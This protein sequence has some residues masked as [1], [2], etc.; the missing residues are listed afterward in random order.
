MAEAASLPLILDRLAAE[1]KPDPERD[2]FV[3]AALEGEGAL[4][5]A[6]DAGAQ[7]AATPAG[8]KPKRDPL[9]A[10]LHAIAVEGFRGIGA[11]ARLELPPG[12]GLTLVVG[13]NGSG[14]SSFAEALELLLTGDT[15]RWSQRAKVWRD[16]WRNLHHPK[17][18][19]TAEFTLE[20]ERGACNVWREW[21]DGAA[22]VAAG[23]THVQIKGKPR[24]GLDA[25]GWDALATYRPFLSYNE[26]GSMLDEGPSRLYDALSAILGLD[27]LVAA[28]DRLKDARAF[29][30]KAHKDADARRKQIVAALAALD[31]ARAKAVAAALDKKDWDLDA[32]AAVLAQAGPDAGGDGAV[33]VLQQLAVVAPPDVAAV[34]TLAAT[35]READARVKAAAGTIAARSESLATILDHALRYHESQ[36]DGACPVCGKAKALDATWRQQKS[37]EIE[38]LR[39]E[40]QE[41][42]AARRALDGA[43]QAARTAVLTTPKPELVR[44]ASEAGLDP[45]PALA[46]L[47]T[48]TAA[49][50]PLAC[51]AQLETTVTALAP[52]LVALRDAARA[53]LQRR[54]DR[55][56]PHALAVAGWLQAARAARH[57]NDVVPAIKK[58]E[59]WL[60]EAAEAIRDERFTPIAERAIAIWEQ[61][62]LQSNVALGRVYLEGSGSRRR[63]ELD[64]SVDG[65]AGTALGVM[66]QG[67]LHSLALSLFVPRATL[68]ESPFRFIVI[69]DP[70]QSMDP[71]R[72]DGLAR[73]LAAAARDRQ[74]VVFT[75]DDR[76]PEAARRLGIDATVVEVTRREGSVVQLRSA[77]DP[78]ARYIE[79]AFAVAK[80]SGVPVQAARRVIPGLCRLALDAACMEAVRRRRL[81]RGE[82]HAD[83]EDLLERS[84][85]LLPRAALALFDDA[86]RADEVYARLNKQDADIAGTVRWCNEGTHIGQSGPAA[87][88]ID[89]IRRTEKIADWLR[90]LP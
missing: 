63:V 71:A 1:P 13:R 44:R 79:D 62:R 22:D 81:A 40:A 56:T 84:G 49:P 77:K 51:A 87:D 34:K 85:K 31:D 35:L 28:Q 86:A 2:A 82:R 23:A 57:A 45:A 74:V 18:R 72:V 58:A 78:I 38:Q 50:E 53:E 10:Y 68:P 39:R 21:E 27:D 52:A 15:F 59:K 75:H 83:V 37:A 65:V 70:V 26:L 24:A 9:G 7:P 54:E 19:I 16:G 47:E 11:E 88:M 64:V 4:R 48:W 42:T 61:L 12:P 41:A 14:K 25:L 90:K 29:R 20:G 32:A 89:R 6:I 80:T 73:V 76:L 30:E 5:A 36:G 67:E 33:A 66:S 55:W 43:L 17:A 8:A 69:D 46:A 3:L 60:K